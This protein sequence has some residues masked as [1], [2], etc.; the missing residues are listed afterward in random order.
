MPTARAVTQ[1]KGLGTRG[2]D[3][4]A[5]LGEG[6]RTDVKR[7]VPVMKSTSQPRFVVVLCMKC[8]PRAITRAERENRK[9]DPKSFG[10]EA[11]FGF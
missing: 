9:D 2:G 7:P 5:V 10:C 11:S 8:I 6:L 3:S 4:S 1:S